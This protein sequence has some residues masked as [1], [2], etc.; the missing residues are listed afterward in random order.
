MQKIHL[1]RVQ[2]GH[3]HGDAD[4]RKALSSNSLQRSPTLSDNQSAGN[5]N[6]KGKGQKKNK[7]NNNRDSKANGG[8]GNDG[9]HTSKANTNTN[10]NATSSGSTGDV[11]DKKLKR[12]LE[13][14]ISCSICG[15][16]AGHNDIDCFA[17]PETEDS[18]A[19]IAEN[20]KDPKMKFFFKNLDNAAAKRKRKS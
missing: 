20:R 17:D 13:M 7:A 15:F 8:Q 16:Q 12:R 11:S 10:T 4:T 14:A 6:N 9:N 18:K 5:G 1:R 3:K 19:K 2:D